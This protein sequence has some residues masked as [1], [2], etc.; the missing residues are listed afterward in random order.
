MDRHT[1][2]GLFLVLLAAI[3]LFTAWIMKLDP[4]LIV[5]WAVAATLA[6]LLMAALLA[7]AMMI[8]RGGR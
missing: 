3:A 7:V 5:A 4:P 2:V 8:L 6:V 1:A